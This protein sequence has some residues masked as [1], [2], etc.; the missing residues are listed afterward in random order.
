MKKGK[1]SGQNA[2]D[3]VILN[4]TSFLIGAVASASFL[5]WSRKKTS[6][7]ADPP[8]EAAWVST[9]PGT[10]P[11]KSDTFFNL[12]LSRADFETVRK[13]KGSMLVFQF[14]YPIESNCG[15]PTLYAYTVE[16]GHP[17]TDCKPAILSYGEASKEPLRGR[18]QV[19]GDQKIDL[20]KLD[21]LIRNVSRK[22]N[23]NYNNLIFKP[24]FLPI[25][26]HMAYDISVD[27]S[28]QFITSN[29]SPP[30]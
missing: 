13:F 6:T 3:D 7:P 19:L 10:D 17:P 18:A 26:P 2:S 1:S 28:E 20:S 5:K 14:Y 4:V 30:G 25:N 21:E 16:K 22:K 11:Y 29:P 8:A 9:L 15:S 24:R 23:G 27:N 12:R